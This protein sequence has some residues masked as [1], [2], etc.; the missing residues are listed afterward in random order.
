MRPSVSASRPTIGRGLPP[1]QRPRPPTHP[2]AKALPPNPLEA[3]GD[4]GGELRTW[5]GAR[6]WAGMGGWWE[7]GCAGVNWPRRELASTVASNLDVRVEDWLQTRDYQ[8]YRGSR[9]CCKLCA[10]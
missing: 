2:S 10:W 6:A 8:H 4:E 7:G 3:I 1:T 9:G 5:E